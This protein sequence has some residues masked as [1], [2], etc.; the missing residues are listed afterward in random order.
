MK[1]LAIIITHPIQYYVPVFQLLAKKCSLKVFYTWGDDVLKEK[2]DPGFE[3]V[4]KWDLPLLE[5]YDYQ[6]LENTAKDKGSH[7]GKGII[8]PD[9]TIAIEDFSPNA[10]LIYGYIYHSHFKAM[11][12]FKGKIP[13]WFRGDSTL[14]NEK[15]NFKSLV[16]WLYLKWI[17]SHVDKAFYVGTN[18]KLY[19]KRYGLHEHRLIFAPHAVDNARFGRINE[20]EVD[21]FMQKLGIKKESD[22]V[23]LYAGKFET[24]KNLVVL[25]K[26]LLTMN[27]LNLKLLLVGNGPEEQELKKLA[28]NEQKILFID[29]QNQSFLPSIYHTSDIFCLPSNSETWGLAIN[30]AM[31]A[32]KAIIASDKVGCAIDLVKP[33]KNGF[34]FKSNSV[35]AL[36]NAL[37][38][39][40]SDNKFASYGQMSSQIINQWTFDK[41]VEAILDELAKTN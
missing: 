10:I 27:N 29:F 14:L 4:I 18:N 38:T 25:V 20:S 32:G 40:I 13:I 30:E 33:G 22:I 21:T 1:K 17:Y 37:Q 34:I 24:V 2:F 16:K 8:N 12:Y 36:T 41:Q 26:A 5:G 9:I 28:N 15:L 3:K 31:A 39:L 11:R 7:H 19:F 23:L 6:F 35:K